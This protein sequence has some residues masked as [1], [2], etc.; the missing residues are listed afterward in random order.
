[1]ILLHGQGKLGAAQDHGFSALLLQT[2]GSG[3]YG[4]G[5]IDGGT[6]L[7]ASIDHIHNGLLARVVRGEQGNAIFFGHSGIYAGQYSAVGG[8]KTRRPDTP[9]LHLL[10]GQLQHI[11]Q[12]NMHRGLHLSMKKVGCI[13][14]HDETVGPIRLQHPGAFLHLGQGILAATEQGGGAVGNGGV[15]VNDHMQVILVAGGLGMGDD[16]AEQVRCGQRP[17]T[18]D[19]ANGF[20]VH[21]HVSPK[22]QCRAARAWAMR[23]KPRWIS[24]IELV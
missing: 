3:L 14:G 2:Q 16:L 1:M 5:I 7:Y 21:R 11:Q 13:A 22:V 17:H 4:G 10:T 12:R 20:L 23:S 15:V 6:G 24:D 8:Q 9:A 18:A 19:D